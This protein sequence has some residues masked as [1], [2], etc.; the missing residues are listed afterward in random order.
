MRVFRCSDCEHTWELPHGS[1]GRGVDL[2]CPQC[3]SKAVH[4]T[5]TGAGWRGRFRSGWR[6]GADDSTAAPQRGGGRG[7][8]RGR[9]GR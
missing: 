3:G 9:S 2:V 4:R 1:G 8:W 6:A 5:E 7:S